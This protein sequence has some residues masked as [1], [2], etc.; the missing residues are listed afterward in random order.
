MVLDF[1][2]KPHRGGQLPFLDRDIDELFD[3]TTVHTDDMVMMR[4]L[5]EL[6][7]RHPIRKMVANDE[8]RRLKLGQHPVHRAETD[9]LMA[10]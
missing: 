8:P 10:S 6:K 9:V 1:E 7:H 5:I 3:M 4:A 2:A